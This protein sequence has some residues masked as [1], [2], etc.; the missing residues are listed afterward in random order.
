MIVAADWPDVA[1]AAIGALP[2]LA[3]AYW[4]YKIRRDTKTPSGA[5]IGEVAEKTYDLSAADVALTQ[6]VLEGQ[7]TREE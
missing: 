6:R 7:R 5:P 2:G 1:I 4:S 3:A